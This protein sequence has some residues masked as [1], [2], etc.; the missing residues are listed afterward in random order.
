MTQTNTITLFGTISKTATARTSKNGR[1]YTAF[2]FSVIPQKGSAPLHYNVVA[3]GKQG[4]FA[5]ELA[6]GTRVKL[7]VQAHSQPDNNATTPLLTA[8]FVRSLQNATAA[9]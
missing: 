8:T 3:F 5:K 1:K 4:H 6:S 2:G 7:A 9:H